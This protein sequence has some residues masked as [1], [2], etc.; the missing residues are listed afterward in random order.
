MLCNIFV[1]CGS[2]VF[3]QFISGN[4]S[5]KLHEVY[6]SL[7]GFDSDSCGSLG[8][9]CRSIAQAVC[10]VGWGGIIF[11]NGTGA[12]EHPYDCKPH[13][14]SDNHP[15]IYVNKS[16]ILKIYYSVPHVSCIEG[17][18]FQ[19]DTEEERPLQI[20]I[21]GII[22]QQTSLKFEDYSQ[23]IQLL[24]PRQLNGFSH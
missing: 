24:F 23:D 16:L 20:K 14:T 12:K 5:P 1:T 11:L 17:F 18:H 9:P 10:Q 22:F 2:N 3:N 6:V 21:A 8:L 19:R 7:S 13:L 15:G 4:C